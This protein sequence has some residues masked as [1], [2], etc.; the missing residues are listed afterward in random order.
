[1]KETL[2]NAWA[3]VVEHRDVALRIAGGV[4]GAVVGGLIVHT[5]LNNTSTYDVTVE[6]EEA[7]AE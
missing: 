1:M 6:L 7:P 2:K 4:V 3:K 5:V